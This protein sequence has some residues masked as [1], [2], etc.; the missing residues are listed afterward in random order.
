MFLIF[1]RFFNLKII[2]F[3]T[4]K[5]KNSDVLEEAFLDD[6][7]IIIEVIIIGQVQDQLS[8]QINFNNSSKTW[9]HKLSTIFRL[10]RIQSSF[11]I[12]VSSWKALDP[13]G[14]DLFYYVDSNSN[15]PKPDE[16]SEQKNEKEFLCKILRWNVSKI[17][18]L[19]GSQI[20]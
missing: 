7:S 15:T 13:F 19:T 8:L 14:N 1:W 2:S 17:N 16:K 20:S 3:E 4:R 18:I 5:L 9:C 12:L 10:L 11:Q 6:M